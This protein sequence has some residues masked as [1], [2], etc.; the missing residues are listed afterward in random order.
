MTRLMTLIALSAALVL[1]LPGQGWAPWG[2][3]VAFAEDDGDDGGDDDGDDDDGGG[4]SWGVGEGGGGRERATRSAPRRS[5]PVRSAPARPAFADN[6]VVAI[7]LG[8]G[9]LA[10]LQALGYRVIEQRTL[11]V[12][13]GLQ[14]LRLALPPGRSLDVA[15]AELRR[16]APAASADFNHFYRSEQG[17][18][19]PPCDGP[20]CGPRSQIGWPWL[21]DDLAG[22]DPGGVIGMIDTAVNPDHPALAGRVT[23]LEFEAGAVLVSA[24]DSG[25][26]DAPSGRQHG[27]AVATLLVGAPGSRTPGLLP[28]TRLLAVDAFRRDGGDERADVFALVTGLDRLVDAGARTINLSLA[29]PPNA[30][31]E[32]M[33]ADLGAQ[34]VLL[35]AAVGNGGAQAGPAWPAAYP[36]VLAVTAVDARGAIYRR[37]QQGPH[38]EMAAPG[39]QVWA[40]ASVEGGRPRSGTS[41]AAPF[42]T[43]AAHVLRARGLDPAQTRVALAAAATDLGAPGPDAVFGHG[44]LNAVALCG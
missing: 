44:L 9:D 42:V 26:R 19:E 24:S 36:Q 41:F 25:P 1:A 18:P 22:C 8:P 33:V 2:V 16:I 27:T 6:E 4:R 13:G 35:V 12:L 37:A 34:G 20:A 10:V 39:V 21:P 38:V 30:V 11:P 17:A 5:A 31:L 7:G 32:R 28:Q 43:A 3:G 15:R 14:A 29:G 40:A 23:V